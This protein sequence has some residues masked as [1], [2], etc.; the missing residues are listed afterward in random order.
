[1][2]TWVGSWRSIEGEKWIVRLVTSSIS[3]TLSMV[4]PSFK[5]GSPLEG[6]SSNRPC[7]I[8]SPLLR[9]SPTRDNEPFLS[10]ISSFSIISTVT[11]GTH[12][13]RKCIIRQA[14]ISATIIA[15]F[16]YH[17]QLLLHTS[18]FTCSSSRPFLHTA[19][20]EFT[21]C[22]LLLHH[23]LMK[24]V[25]RLNHEGRESDYIFLKANTRQS[26]L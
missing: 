26:H 14:K 2:E 12:L 22:T 20:M 21:P 23:S 4:A 3:D 10:D 19:W 9:P 24:Y 5:T 11:S 17:S 1:M 16:L 15:S 8:Q 18:P 7:I 6:K 25:S 13:Q